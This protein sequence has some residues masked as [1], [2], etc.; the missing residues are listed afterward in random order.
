MRGAIGGRVADVHRRQGRL[1]EAL[2]S[3]R[4][5]QD[6]LE[7]DGDLRL[8]GEVLTGQGMLMLQMRQFELAEHYHLRALRFEERLGHERGRAVCWNNLALVAL[9]RGDCGLAEEDAKKALE[10][11]R[12]IRDR[13]GLRYP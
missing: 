2:E 1:R 3:Y 12:K 5:A 11:S 7:P 4:H 6:L 10:E 9:E 13:H 8:L